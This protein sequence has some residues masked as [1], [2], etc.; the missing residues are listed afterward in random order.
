MGHARESAPA[1]AK[2]LAVQTD[3][4]GTARTAIFDILRRKNWPVPY[5]FRAIRNPL[6]RQWEGCID[7]LRA[8]P[9][10]RALP[11][12]RAWQRVISALPTPPQARPWA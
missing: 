6:H 8:A 5:D 1:G 10:E 4:D 2:A 3:G 9:E 12:I 7:A 11:T